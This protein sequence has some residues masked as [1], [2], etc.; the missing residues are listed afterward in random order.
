MDLAVSPYHL[1]LREAPA[2]AALLLAER[3]VTMLPAPA[4][5][6]SAGDLKSVA[7]SAPRYH[8]LLSSWDELSALWLTGVV[9]PE[10]CGESPIRDVL[11]ALE[12]IRTDPRYEALRRFVDIDRFAGDDRSMEAL[13]SDLLRGGPDPAM[14][15]PMASG[16]D[17]FA[18]RNDLVVVRGPASSVA[19][20]AELKL[21]SERFRVALPMI[22]Q[23]KADVFERAREALSEQRALLGTTMRAAFDADCSDAVRT[24]GDA[25]SS[26]FGDVQED[27]CRVVRSDDI[28]V[29]VEM[30][31]IRGVTLPVDAVLRSSLVAARSFTRGDS[32][33]T[34]TA[35]ATSIDRGLAPVNALIISPIVQ[36]G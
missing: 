13:A 7:R 14:T 19:Q 10:Y 1:T 12:A 8:D 21:A 16:L 35:L 5:I 29:R 33:K 3:V 11:D 20:R 23:S 26:A 28:S 34:S 22:V 32:T 15:V 27:L 25:F 2:M 6:R 4:S 30:L 18:S 31:S 9:V 24:A 17:A 36:R